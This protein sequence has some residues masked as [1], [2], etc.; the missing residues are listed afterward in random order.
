MLVKSKLQFGGPPGRKKALSA[1]PERDLQEAVSKPTTGSFGQV[2]G[3]AAVLLATV[4]PQAANAAE[5]FIDDYAP[6]FDLQVTDQVYQEYAIG[7]TGDMRADSAPAQKPLLKAR[8]QAQALSRLDNTEHDS[9]PEVGIVETPGE[10]VSFEPRSGEIHRY[11]SRQQGPGG[12]QLLR[13]SEAPLKL[14]QT[15]V[16]WGTSTELKIEETNDGILRYQR[17][18]REFQEDDHAS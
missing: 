3:A 11:D 7:P 2:V 17:V 14:E 10:W 16:E 18:T 15:T 12:S 6:A 1:P 4:G 8:S 9:N 13:Y 5:E